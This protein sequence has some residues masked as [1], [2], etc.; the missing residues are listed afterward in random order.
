MRRILGVLVVVSLLLGG[1]VTPTTAARAPRLLSDG[2]ARYP[3]A[4]RLSGGDVVASVDT[5]GGVA[6]VYRSGTGASF[7]RVGVI[8]D[9]EAVRGLC[10]AHLFEL[11]RRVGGLAKGTLLWAGSVGYAYGRMMTRIWRSGDRGSSWSYLSTCGVSVENGGMWEPELSVDDAGLLV[12][13][14]ADETV[15]GHSQ[16]LARTTSADGLTWSEKVLTVAVSPRG[17]RPGMPYVRRLPEGGYLMTYEICGQRGQYFCEAY[18][19]TSP[20]GAD[21]GDPADPGTPVHSADGRY[22]AHTPTVELGPGGRIVLIGQMLMDQDGKVADGNGATLFVSDNGA[23]GPWVEAPAPV[24]VPKARDVNCP[25]YHPSL[26]VLN[27]GRD[28]L[29]LASDYDEDGRCVVRYAT[30]ALPPR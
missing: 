9:P 24:A 25:N 30:G 10:C 29:E 20:D 1:V 16:V 18:F 11:P 26:V 14:F 5:G 6:E 13:H 19:R 15:P 2:P 12:C 8:E 23:A 17:Y 7:R 21:W 4:I 28:V 3:H 27:G 22:F